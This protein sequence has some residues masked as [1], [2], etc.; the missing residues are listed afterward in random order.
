MIFDEVIKLKAHPLIVR[1]LQVIDWSTSQFAKQVQDQD[2]RGP[3]SIPIYVIS[4][5]RQKWAKNGL[6]VQ[7][8]SDISG[9]KCDQCSIFHA[10]RLP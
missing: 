3:G 9:H 10:D 1:L 2:T 4:W 7:F 6:D 8:K 5:C